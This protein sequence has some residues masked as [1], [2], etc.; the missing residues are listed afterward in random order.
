MKHV[1]V[2]ARMINASG[3]GTVIKNIL[4]RIIPQKREWH[5]YI[6]GNI[7]E[8]KKFDFLCQSKQSS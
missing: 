6:L 1:T 2:D 8:L 3:I 7:V 5:F 4:K